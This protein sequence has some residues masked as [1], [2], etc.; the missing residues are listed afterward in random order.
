MVDITR[1]PRE[2]ITPVWSSNSW[3]ANVFRLYE[4]WFGRKAGI[5]FEGSMQ[6]GIY[7]HGTWENFLS[8]QEGR[9]R[10][11]KNPFAFKLVPLPVLVTPNGQTFH[12]IFNFAIAFDNVAQ[13][14]TSGGNATSISGS[15]TVTGSNP[16]IF[17]WSAGN[18]PGTSSAVTGATYNSVAL[19]KV[20]DVTLA[21][22]RVWDSWILVGPATGSHTLAVASSTSTQQ[23]LG[24][25]SYSGT[26]QSGQPDASASQAQNGTG[27]L[28][29]SL[30]VGTA[31]CWLV[32]MAGERGI[33][34]TANSPGVARNNGINIGFYDS[35]A[36]VATGSNAVTI[37]VNT[38]GSSAGMV[39]VSIKTAASATVNSGFFF[40]A[41]S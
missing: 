3:T 9:L 23:Y 15:Y 2:V 26:L 33:T 35:N 29:G 40:A 24:A 30:T 4:Y 31:N 12:S 36:T 25:V 17:S 19:T 20:N 22:D 14:N 37:T 10:A 13:V 41:A 5:R 7:V 39:M 28:S 38:T 32:Y 34:S 1:H 27:G 18:F 16:L 8:H 11:L 6:D 21:S